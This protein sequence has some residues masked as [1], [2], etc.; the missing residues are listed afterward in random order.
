MEERKIKPPVMTPEES[1]GGNAIKATLYKAYPILA[2]RNCD[3]SYYECPVGETDVTQCTSVPKKINR[4]GVGSFGGSLRAGPRHEDTPDRKPR[5]ADVYLDSKKPEELQI[6]N[7]IRDKLL[8]HAA[9]LRVKY[10]TWNNVTLFPDGSKKP[11]SARWQANATKRHEN[12]L[13][14][15]FTDAYNT[16]AGI[17]QAFTD[18]FLKPASSK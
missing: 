10:V 13:H 3:F 6:G 8:A 4:T 1:W 15:E 17:L 16:N 18:V 5:A 12:H 11:L 14:V 7:E 2:R 9:K